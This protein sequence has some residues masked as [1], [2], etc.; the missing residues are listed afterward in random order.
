MSEFNVDDFLAGLERD[1]PQTKGSDRIEKILMNVRDNQGTVVLVP[2]MNKLNNNF[3]Y[4]V[5]R[6]MEW[7]GATSKL[8][9]GEAWYKILEKPLYGDLSEEDS[10]L[11]DQAASLF[12]FLYKSDQ[13]D[14]NSLRIRNYTLIYGVLVSHT[15]TDGDEL[16]DN[17]GKACLFIFT[18]HDPIN[19]LTSAISSKCL[20]LKGNKSW[21][22]HILSPSNT[23]R[24]GVMSITFTKAS[25]VGY[26]CNV[27]FEMNSEFSQIVDPDQVFEED[28][29]K[30]FGNP[31]RD[32]VGWAG[33]RDHVFNSEVFKELIIDMK[34]AVKQLKSEEVA[35][36]PITPTPPA[37]VAVTP[38]PAQAAVTPVESPSII[39]DLPF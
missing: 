15:G 18:S 35:S 29:T 23:G 31:V 7:K 32:L 2:F 9:S 14:F 33:D 25:N 38:P 3:Y 5:D 16:K 22:T 11:Y 30:H 24:K 26:N 17:E 37:Q 12:D 8:D 39:D 20:A 21:I 34:H 4:K 6:V 13:F 27:G 19:A 10:K 28:I 1:K 36:N